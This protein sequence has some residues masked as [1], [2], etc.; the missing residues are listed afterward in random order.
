MENLIFAQAVLEL[1]G[2][3]LYNKLDIVI[4]KSEDNV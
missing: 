4:E 3:S 1:W 2:Q